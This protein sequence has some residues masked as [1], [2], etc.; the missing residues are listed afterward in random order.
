MIESLGG[1]RADISSQA[2]ISV[3]QLNNNVSKGVEV[4]ELKDGRYVTVR[5]DATYFEIAEGK[6]K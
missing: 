5:K 3:Q 2:G 1:S 4:E 6:K